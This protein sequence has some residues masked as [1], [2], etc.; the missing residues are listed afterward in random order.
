MH[1]QEIFLKED[2]PLALNLSFPISLGVL[3]VALS[4]KTAGCG[5]KTSGD[6]A[7]H[8]RKLSMQYFLL[9][10]ESH[11]MFISS[12]LFPSLSFHFIS[13]TGLSF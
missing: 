8:N 3:P 11:C 10:A 6:E 2:H 4:L 13:F 5:I 7:E 12:S 1:L 9:L